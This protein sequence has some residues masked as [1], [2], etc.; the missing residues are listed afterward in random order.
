MCYLHSCIPDDI[1]PMTLKVWGFGPAA[2]ELSSKMGFYN[3]VEGLTSRK[4]PVWR[5]ED[6]GYYLFY[7]S[8]GR[9]MIGKDYKGTRGWIKSEKIGLL[10]IPVVGWRWT[11]G[12]DWRS[13]TKLIVSNTIRSL[14]QLKLLRSV[15]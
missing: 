4:R 15:L 6:T 7:S 3:R 2:A 14:Q 8:R 13:D 11:D 10:K 5:M 9:W 1:Y 12:K